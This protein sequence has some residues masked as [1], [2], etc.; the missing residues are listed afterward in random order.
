M[1]KITISGKPTS[2]DTTA[3]SPNGVGTT[4]APF[5]TNRGF[6]EAG[7]ELLALTM[8]ELNG[9][10]ECAFF[11]YRRVPGRPAGIGQIFCH[12]GDEPAQEILSS[13]LS[14]KESFSGPPD[15]FNIS[16]ARA[17]PLRVLGLRFSEGEVG[18]AGGYA[19]FA[20]EPNPEIW[21]L[22]RSICVHGSAFLSQVRRNAVRNNA[23]AIGKS[24]QSRM[25][26]VLRLGADT[27][28]EADELGIVGKV[29][30]LSE[31][32]EAVVLRLLEG[33]TLPLPLPS[34]ETNETAERF[35][36]LTLQVRDPQGTLNVISLSGQHLPGEGWHG[37]ARIVPTGQE[38]PTTFRQARS[39]VEQLQTAHEQEA[40]LRRETELILDGLR[41]LTSG[42]ASRDIFHQLLSLLAPALE[43]QESVV[44]QRDWSNRI[45]ACAG[46][47]PDL[48]AADW[49][50]ADGLFRLEEVAVSL[51]LPAAL[52]VPGDRRFRSA[53][54]VK[55]QGGSKE[56]NLICLHERP[57]FFTA[58]HRGLA[59]R[60]SLV[61]SQAF[62]NEEERQK[63][64]DASK[65]AAIGEMAAGIVHEINQP[66]TAMTLAVGNLLDSLE[67][68]DDIDREWLGEK[69]GK[70]QN[71]IGRM[72]KIIA[73]MKMLSRRSDGTL[74]NF[75][76]DSAI[77][78]AIGIVQHKLT[79]ANVALE[80]SGERNLKALG[81][82]TEFAQVMLNLV[83]NAHDAMVMASGKAKPAGDKEK[84]I[85]ITTKATGPE[86]IECLIRDT[87]SGFPEAHMEKAFESFFTTK[88]VG[89]GTGLGLAL[90]RRIVQN[91]GGTITLGNWAG[92][93]EIRVIIRKTAG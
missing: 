13:L 33:R 54:A 36:N 65:L 52:V 74:E 3:M 56:T 18:F 26:E 16:V 27:Y 1:G 70:L 23:E 81:N 45:T 22:T 91:M 21:A 79:Q 69:L 71:Q 38:A 37:I 80:I 57:K 47:S 82:P 93:A 31:G 92:G 62:L 55:L 84:R 34:K 76:L 41:I 66:L 6:V 2:R 49:T 40:A 10:V 53:L 88:A 73:N 15:Y 11:E 75:D 90:C 19:V 17:K 7:L 35:Y 44:L 87:G 77:H 86:T 61:A 42:I 5:K 8:S 68:G 72:S 89:Q 85:T 25:G 59:A 46:T 14:S 48:V 83:T 64:V 29:V 50:E 58:R 12:P 24:F 9:C 4:P 32:P 51:E 60:L 67:T 39:L 43:F 30:E 63:V 78:D 20:S 28:W